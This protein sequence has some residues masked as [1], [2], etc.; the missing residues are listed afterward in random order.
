MSRGEN[1]F[2]YSTLAWHAGMD[3]YLQWKSCFARLG[4][5]HL[6]EL[7]YDE[8]EYMYCGFETCLLVP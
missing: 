3:F 1:V 4:R 6:A 7:L 5:D 2:L 8:D